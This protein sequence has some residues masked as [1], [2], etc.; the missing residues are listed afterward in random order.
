MTT[1]NTMDMMRWEW[2]FTRYSI[3][4]LT[5]RWRAILLDAMVIMCGICFR[6][7]R[8]RR[9]ATAL[10]KLRKTGIGMVGRNV[11]TGQRPLGEWVAEWKRRQCNL[12]K[13]RDV[14]L[15]RGEVISANEFRWSIW[16]R[17]E[18]TRFCLRKYDFSINRCE[19]HMVETPETASLTKSKECSVEKWNEK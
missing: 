17:Y 10:N 9:T 2:Q 7:C 19:W 18:W 3:V 5:L 16:T 11:R 4:F 13:I 6:N 12:I 1:I 14:C 8:F 15:A